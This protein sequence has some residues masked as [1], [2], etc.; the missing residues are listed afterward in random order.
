MCNTNRPVST[1]RMS[2]LPKCD[3]GQEWGGQLAADRRPSIYSLFDN[4]HKAIPFT[5]EALNRTHMQYQ[6]PSRQRKD[7]C[8]AKNVITGRSGAGSEQPTA[9]PPIK[10]SL[11]TL[12]K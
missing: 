9:A 12:A 4:T 2:V 11:T 5:S 1:A 10:R 6:S 3:H 8:I 7:V